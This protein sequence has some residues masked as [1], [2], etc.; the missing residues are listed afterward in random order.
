LTTESSLSCTALCAGYG[1]KPVLHDISADIPRGTLTVLAGPNGCGKSTLLQCLAGAL[2]LRSGEITLCGKPLTAYTPLERARILTILPQ[3][4][5][6]TELTAFSAALS[7][8]FPY[9]SFP[10][11]YGESDRAAAL[12][13]LRVVGAEQFRD[14]P[15]RELSGGERQ[16]VYLAAALAQDTEILLLDEPCT[17]LDIGAELDLLELLKE[18]ARKG[19]TVVL[20]HH[21][22]VSALEIADRVIVMKE[23]EVLA[24]GGAEEVLG[25]VEDAFGVKLCR[26]PAFTASPNPRKGYSLP[27]F[28]KGTRLSS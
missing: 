9:L 19:K 13:A 17:G 10:R 23:G 3:F 26:I 14:R 16:K 22:L 8:R 21:N 2:A 24:Q 11:R 28:P 20:S 5:I 1:K 27:E 25:A 6:P 7:G 4:R 18:L 12:D 15:V